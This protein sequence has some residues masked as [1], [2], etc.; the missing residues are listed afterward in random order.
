MPW[1]KHFLLAYLTLAGTGFLLAQKP[2]PNASAPDKAAVERG[3]ALYKR[4]CAVCHFDSSAAKKVGPG[5]KGIY[6]RGKFADGKKV[7]DAGMQAW[8][9]NGGKNMPGFKTALNPDQLRD[10]LAYL[11]TL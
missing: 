6:Q 5:M 3:Q 10:L 7:D 11:R 9:E 2:A 4:H 1:L 8:I